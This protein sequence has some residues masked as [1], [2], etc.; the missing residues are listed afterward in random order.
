MKV[1]RNASCPCGSGR[2][3][4]KC[5]GDSANVYTDTEAPSKDVVG[6]LI[7][8]GGKK[9]I[10][11]EGFIT[12]QLRRD[13]PRIAQSFDRL[14]E[15]D[16][17]VLD[18]YASRC[19]FAVYVGLDKAK[20][21]GEEWRSACGW[22]LM[23]ALS[24]LVSAID[25]MRNGFILQPGILIRNILEVLTAVLCIVMDKEH[26]K[27]FQADR[28]KPEAE[29]KT[30][31][32]VLPIFGQLYG[33][34]SGQFAHVRKCYAQLH[35]IIEYPSHNYKPLSANVGFARMALWLIYVVT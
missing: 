5:C 23:N 3:F 31:N 26:W 14:C 22:L 1:G 9:I 33:F 24:T 7:E 29:L 15:P 8:D 11:K 34:F 4:K 10:F 30:A 18:K 2:K 21:Q 13:A 19:F 16:L 17:V 28:L 6:M 20:A 32:K 25:L 27:A 35:P 12:N